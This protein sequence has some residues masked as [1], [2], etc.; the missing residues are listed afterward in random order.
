MASWSGS[1]DSPASSETVRGVDP[2][3]LS[4]RR[5]AS[6]GRLPPLKS[7][8]DRLELSFFENHPVPYSTKYN[9]PSGPFSISLTLKTLVHS[10]N[11]SIRIRLPFS[12]LVNT[13]YR[14][15]VV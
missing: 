7:I 12:S 3:V 15:R 2:L 5:P 13:L 8:T 10:M 4:M 9:L 11:G 6:G 1:D 14:K